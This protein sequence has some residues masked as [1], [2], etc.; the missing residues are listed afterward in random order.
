MGA[1]KATVN[2]AR[3]VTRNWITSLSG[4]S[5]AAFTTAKGFGVTYP[6]MVHGHPVDAVLV[7]AALSG[8]VLGWAAKDGNKH[9]TLAEV[10]A[11]TPQGGNS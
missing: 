7:G 6:T 8:A 2:A 11:S 5:L 9:S 1:I 4:T 3:H 10:Q